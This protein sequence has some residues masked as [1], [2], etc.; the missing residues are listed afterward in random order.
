MVINLSNI[1]IERTSKRNGI[2]T[3]PPLGR[4]TKRLKYIRKWS[5][6]LFLGIP[7]LKILRRRNDILNFPKMDFAHNTV[8]TYPPIQSFEKIP[9]F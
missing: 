6:G 9:S 8:A 5:A 4:V 1:V 2:R 7:G 3:V